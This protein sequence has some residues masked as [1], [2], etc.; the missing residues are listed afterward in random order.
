MPPEEEEVGEEEAEEEEDGKGERRGGE[1]SS[2]AENVS[3]QLRLMSSMAWAGKIN[4][5]KKRE[6]MW[7]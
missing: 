2:M 1:D 7:H 6:K 3:R 4:T 5:R